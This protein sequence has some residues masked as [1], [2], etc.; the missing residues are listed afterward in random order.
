MQNGVVGSLVYRKRRCPLWSHLHNH[1][2]TCRRSAVQ[3]SASLLKAGSLV[4]ISGSDRLCIAN[5]TGN[6]LI[7]PTIFRGEFCLHKQYQPFLS[8]KGRGQ[9]CHWWVARILPVVRVKL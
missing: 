1:S 3:G 9:R 7:Y 6:V 4:G 8:P 2:I 5:C